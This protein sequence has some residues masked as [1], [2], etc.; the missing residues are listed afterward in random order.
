MSSK[1]K[2]IAIIGGGPTGLGSIKQCR[3]DGHEVVCFELTDKI[4]G[5]WCYR[6]N[7]ASV[8]KSTTINNSKEFL[9][10]SEVTPPAELPNYAHN[11][12]VVSTHFN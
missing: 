10:V 11:T 1:P 4:G 9:A 6:E 12:L 5:L 8:T 7:G 2:K 3:D